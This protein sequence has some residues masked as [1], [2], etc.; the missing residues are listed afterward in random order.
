MDQAGSYRFALT[1][2]DLARICEVS[3]QACIR[4]GMSMLTAKAK[5][6]ELPQLAP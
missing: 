6:P 4:R 5:F 1:S 2:S 3:Y